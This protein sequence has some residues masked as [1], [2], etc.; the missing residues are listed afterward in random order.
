MRNLSLIATAAIA[1]LTPFAASAQT[2]APAPAPAEQLS[3]SPTPP[4]EDW[5]AVSR[6]TTRVYLVDV[7]SIKVSG[8]VS[9]ITL[10]RVPL[11]PAATTDHSYTLVE[12]EYRC[13]AKQSRAVAETDH[14]EAGVALDRLETGDDFDAYNTDS[15]YGFIGAVV[16]DDAR[17][18]PPTF[19]SIAAFMDAGRVGGS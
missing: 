5:N 7:N 4:G 17:A 19:P 13:A 8:D 18:S 16:C 15:L 2:A 14:D 3:T 6:S 10:A 11:H 1:V 12:L 9:A